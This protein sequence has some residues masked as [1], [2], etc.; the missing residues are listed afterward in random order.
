M[1]A[2]FPIKSSILQG[3]LLSMFLYALSI[4]PLLTRLKAALT[5]LRLGIDTRK[6]VVIDYADDVTIILT[7]PAHIPLL[8][9]ILH[10]YEQA[11]GEMFNKRKHK[12]LLLGKWNIS[13]RHIIYSYSE[14]PRHYISPYN[15]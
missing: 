13:I 8:Q 15:K 10:T 2:A 7:E 5:G 6:I 14:D 11:T 1:L 4:N 9:N 3:Y 12:A